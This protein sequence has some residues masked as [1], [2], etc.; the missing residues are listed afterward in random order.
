MTERT[1]AVGVLD[2]FATGGHPVRV[3]KPLHQ[4]TQGGIRAANHSLRKE[5]VARNRIDPDCGE[6]HEPGRR[7]RL[8]VK[9][10]LRF[11]N[12]DILVGIGRL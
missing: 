3:S 4:V 7:R 8:I 9:N 2:I 12:Q 10:A 1:D 11:G 5:F 6:G